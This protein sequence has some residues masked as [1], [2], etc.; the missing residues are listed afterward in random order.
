MNLLT[1]RNGN[2]S[3]FGQNERYASSGDFVFIFFARASIVSV[4]LPFLQ[5]QRQRKMA[6]RFFLH[7]NHHAKVFLSGTPLLRPVQ[8]HRTFLGSVQ[9][10]NLLH[11]FTNANSMEPFSGYIINFD[12]CA[13]FAI[14]IKYV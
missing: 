12:I 4:I 9:Y 13:V 2:F 3:Y 5:L 7:G 10:E 1:I 6:A 11:V 14:L 8:Y